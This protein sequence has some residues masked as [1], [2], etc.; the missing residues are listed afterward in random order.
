MKRFNL[1]SICCTTL[2]NAKCPFCKRNK[3]KVK[4]ENLDLSIILPFL[5]RI[6]YLSLNGSY[7]D[8]I[9][10]PYLFNFLN[11]CENYPYLQIEIATNGGAKND[12]FWSELG[13]IKNLKVVFGVDGLE[14][15]HYRYRQTDFNKVIH[16][17][18]TYIKSGGNAIVQMILFKYNQHQVKDLSN[19]SKSI[20]CSEFKTI[21]SNIYTNEYPNPD[22]TLSMMN[23]IHPDNISK[24][25]W[26][27]RNGKKFNSISI[28]VFGYV[29]PC[30]HVIYSHPSVLNSKIFD[31]LRNLFLK[32]KNLINLYNNDIDDIIENP[33]FQYIY[34][35]STKLEICKKECWSS[36]LFSNVREIK[37][38]EKKIYE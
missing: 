3:S 1:V 2:C 9:F 33:Y 21:R 10:N 35:N 24:C 13:K 22:N 18:K 4:E 28:D 19:L 12:S 36:V 7:G 31:E 23:S 30:C 8:A 17:M 5:H 20:G 6:D 14:D 27:Y 37:T 15:T 32:N 16:N 11:K 29:H 34:N 26:K 25:Y 38:I